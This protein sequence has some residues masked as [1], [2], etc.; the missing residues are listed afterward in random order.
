MKNHG[1]TVRKPRLS[2]W[3]MRPALAM[4][5]IIPFLVLT[6]YFIPSFL[7]V[8]YAQSPERACSQIKVNAQGTAGASITVDATATGILVAAKNEARCGLLIKSDS[9]NPMRCGPS[10][11]P[12]A[13]VVS[14]TV[15]F[16]WPLAAEDA[17]WLGWGA[18]E[19]WRCFRTTGTSN[20]VSVIELLP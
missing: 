11:G 2:A 20:A 16:L 10:T 14:A 15:G 4:Y 12:Y 19:A 9:V 5:L 1:N 8:S 6:S 17:L 3:L 18:Q 13:I 7:G